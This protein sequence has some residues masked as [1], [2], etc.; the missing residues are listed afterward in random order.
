MNEK[1]L[2]VNGLYLTETD[3]GERDDAGRASRSMP[4]VSSST[5]S[6]PWPSGRVERDK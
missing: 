6:R 2:M 3:Y 1:G 5:C 4:A